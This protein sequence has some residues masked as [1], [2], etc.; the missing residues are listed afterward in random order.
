MDTLGWILVNQGKLRR[1]VT[2]LRR[3]SVLAPNQGDIRYHLVVAL[4]RRGETLEARTALEQLLD[5]GLAF[6]EK[7]SAQELLKKLRPRR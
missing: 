1:A 3:A 4:H 2:L 7:P 6:T 5:S